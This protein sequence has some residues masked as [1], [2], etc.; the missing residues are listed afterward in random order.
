MKEIIVYDTLSGN[1]EELAK[2]IK[3]AKPS[4]KLEKI[5]KETV[6]T[7]NEIY[8]IGTP[9]IKGMCTDKIKKFLMS[10]ENKKIFLFVTAGYGGNK[11]YYERLKE[12]ILE[13]I[14]PSN[15][16]IGTFFCQGKMQESVK[17]R[18]IKLIKEHPEDKQLE[19]NLTNFEQ[20]K[21][22]PDETDKKNLIEEIRKTNLT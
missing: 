22:H 18:Y 7:D 14:P 4:A 15:Q 13:V 6:P 21:T 17:E 5:T 8:Y 10:L 11:D 12:R 9:I 1:T 19:V 2:E 16:I 3:K 20:A